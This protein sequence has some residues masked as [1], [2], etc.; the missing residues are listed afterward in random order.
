[1]VFL[2]ATSFFSFYYYFVKDA[3]IAERDLVKHTLQLVNEDLESLKAEKDSLQK[4]KDALQKDID[5]RKD[6]D[7]FEKLE[8]E[9]KREYEVIRALLQTITTWILF[10]KTCYSF[11]S[12]DNLCLA[13]HNKLLISL[14]TERT[15]D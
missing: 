4:D 6:A 7:E 5:E 12:I 2:N 3:V 1:M 14:C 13:D 15:G 8:Q 11:S 9:S 10:S